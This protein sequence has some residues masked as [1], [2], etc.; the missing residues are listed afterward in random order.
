MLFALQGFSNSYR[1]GLNQGIKKYHNL[2]K[3]TNNRDE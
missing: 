1:K 2:M 3:Y